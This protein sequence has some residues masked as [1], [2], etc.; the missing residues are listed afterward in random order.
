LDSRCV[1]TWRKKLITDALCEFPKR[2]SKHDLHPESLADLVGNAKVAGSRHA[3]IDFVETK[4]IGGSYRLVRE[5]SLQ[6]RP[7]FAFFDI[8][9]D[10]LHIFRSNESYYDN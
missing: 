9:G 1:F 8:P 3:F 5:A 4:N 2:L 6:K 7:A 10:D